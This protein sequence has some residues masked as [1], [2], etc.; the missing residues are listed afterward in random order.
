MNRD[1][2][3]KSLKVGDEVLEEYGLSG[4]VISGITG[5]TAT[6]WKI[7]D[8]LFHKQTGHLRGHRGSYS[9]YIREIIES[10]R[11]KISRRKLLSKFQECVKIPERLNDN[12]LQRI[13]DITKE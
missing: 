7:G 1:E 5:E 11:A 6:C 3:L 13:I 2:W 12:Q 10:D 4:E 9:W 8:R